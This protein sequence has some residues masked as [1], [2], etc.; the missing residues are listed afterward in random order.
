MSTIH[1]VWRLHETK[2]DKAATDGFLGHSYTR[3]Q[4]ME[5]KSKPKEIFFCLVFHFSKG[6]VAFGFRIP[7]L[8]RTV[9]SAKRLNCK[10]KP[11][12]EHHSN[13]WNHIVPINENVPSIKSLMVTKFYLCKVKSFISQYFKINFFY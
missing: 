2:N 9:L 11:Q 7:T 6:S 5:C 1:N 8:Y 10:T 12:Y 3:V 13:L 4:N